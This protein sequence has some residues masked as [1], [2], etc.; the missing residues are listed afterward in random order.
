MGPQLRIQ[1]ERRMRS[2]LGSLASLAH[3]QHVVENCRKNCPRGDAQAANLLTDPESSMAGEVDQVPLR[4]SENRILRGFAILVDINGFVKMVTKAV[5]GPSHGEF[6]AQFVRDILEHAVEAIE[7]SDGEIVGIMGDAVLGVLPAGGPI[8][9]V[10]E[11]IAAALNRVCKDISEHQAVS[12]QDW[13]YSPGGPSLKICI[14]LGSMRV[15]ALR[16]RH[17]GT[18]QMLVSPAINHASRIGRAGT[19]NRCLIGPVA[20]GMPQFS[21]K[22]LRGPLRIKEDDGKSEYVYYESSLANLWLEGA[23][24]D[25]QIS[26]LI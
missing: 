14:E 10:C 7:K 2:R 3:P 16:T 13:E 9:D 21:E 18:F 23:R 1:H 11:G 12:P 17:L 4:I 6:I 25:E 20:A 15:T 22:S 5:D 24:E 19:G 26:Y 8:C